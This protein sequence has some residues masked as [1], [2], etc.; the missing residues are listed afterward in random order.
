[1]ADAKNPIPDGKTPDL[2]PAQI[3]AYRRMTAEE[4]WLQMSRLYWQAWEMKMAWL[5]QRHPDWTEG[6]VEEETRRIFIN[7]GTG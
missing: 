7:A 4:R 6:Q 2:H 5:R 3:D 1:M